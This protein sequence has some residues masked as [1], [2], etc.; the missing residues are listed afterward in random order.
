MRDKRFEEGDVVTIG[1]PPYQYA[2]AN[3]DIS[4][5]MGYVKHF[6]GHLTSKGCHVIYVQSKDKL[7][8][9]LECELVEYK[10]GMFPIY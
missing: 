7:Y 3:V 4:G 6:G 9:L 8:K 2:D 1:K 10:N 5:K